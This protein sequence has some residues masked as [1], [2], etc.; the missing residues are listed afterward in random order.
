MDMAIILRSKC[1]WWWQCNAGDD[2][3]AGDGAIGGCAWYDSGCGKGD[4]GGVGDSSRSGWNDGGGG[5]ACG[6]NPD[7]LEVFVK[8][9]W[10]LIAYA[11][12]VLLLLKLLCLC[13]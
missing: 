9:S 6:N 12:L 11:N 3:V 2:T 10:M 13:S 8:W 5:G 7:I 4:S 1:Q